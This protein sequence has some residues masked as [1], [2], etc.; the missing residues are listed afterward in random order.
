M[1]SLRHSHHLVLITGMS[2]S[3]KSMALHK[4]EDS[5]FYC[6]DNLPA[7]LFKS[8]WLRLKREKISQVAMSI[9]ARS[10]AN[11][12]NLA[13]QLSEVATL[14]NELFDIIFLDAQDEV[15]IKRY[16]ET[17]R[18]HHLSDEN[19]SLRE[20]LA[21]ERTMVSALLPKAHHIDT[22]FL[23]PAD[24][25]QRIDDL[26]KLKQEKKLLL[27]FQ[28]F[29]YKKGVPLDSDLVF[30]VRFLPNPYYENALRS[31]DGR[32]PDVIQFINSHPQ[33]A[34]IVKD[35]YQFISRWIPFYR[36]ESRT[37]LSIAIGCTGGKHRSV[38]V[39]ETLS[40]KLSSEGIVI[41]RHRDVE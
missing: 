29:G 17:R 38:F 10:R 16:S 3:G 15:L 39:A 4:L 13:E 19:N 30:D 6:I 41:V 31:K 9:D 20:A 22:S 24:L 14:N 12:M 2:G 5:G 40:K 23:L 18:R 8:V 28:S 34:L 37:S 33:A 21:R 11:L 36:Q 35:L 32:D 1:S 7:S 26:I 27:F 25:R